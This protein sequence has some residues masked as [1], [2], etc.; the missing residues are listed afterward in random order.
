MSHVHLDSGQRSNTIET[1]ARYICRSWKILDVAHCG[2][3]TLVAEWPGITIMMRSPLGCNL[4]TPN[5][6]KFPGLIFLRPNHHQKENCHPKERQWDTI[7]PIMC[8][9]YTTTTP[10]NCRT[11]HLLLNLHIHCPGDV[12]HKG[13][14]HEIKKRLLSKEQDK[15]EIQKKPK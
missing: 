11:G 14:H 4:A 9:R 2:G 5:S 1:Q 13:R 6:L 7:D 15:K 10:E 12:K 8:S 3:R